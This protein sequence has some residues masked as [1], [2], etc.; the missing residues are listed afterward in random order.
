MLLRVVISNCI[1]L[2]LL[3]VLSG[4]NEG[5]YTD[6]IAYL[7]DYEELSSACKSTTVSGFHDGDGGQLNPYIL[8]KARHLDILRD[9]LIDNYNEYYNKYYRVTEDIDYKGNP[10]NIFYP[11]GDIYD[12]ELVDFVSPPNAKPFQGEFDGNNKTIKGLY[13]EGADLSY[14]GLFQHLGNLATV[15]NLTINFHYNLTG[16]NYF[17]GGLAAYSEATIDTVTAYG[18]ITGENLS[19]A[20]LISGYQKTGP[21]GSVTVG[22][23]IQSTL[24]EE[25]GAIAGSVSDSTIEDSTLMATF[26]LEGIIL[27]SKVNGAA[28]IGGV[29]GRAVTDV[30]IE[31]IDN[32]FKI[33][34]TADYCGGIVGSGSDSIVITNCDNNVNIVSSGD[35]VGGIGGQ[36][37]DASLTSVR[38]MGEGSR[39][40]EGNDFVAGLVGDA[41]TVGIYTSMSLVSVT[42][43]DSVCGGLVGRIAD[44]QIEDSSVFGDVTATGD[45]VGG[46]AGFA[47]NLLVDGDATVSGTSTIV[48]SDVEGDN[49]VGGIIG[50]SDSEL[51]LHNI[52]RRGDV[53]GTGDNVGGIAGIVTEGL[54]AKNIDGTA[55][56]SVDGTGG[57]NV[58]GGFGKISNGVGY[59]AY[60]KNIHISSS[61]VGAQYVGGIAGYL[62]ENTI[63]TQSSAEVDL[64][65]TLQFA[66]GIV[67]YLTSGSSSSI[68]Y[69]T[70][71]AAL[72]AGDISAAQ[73]FAGGICGKCVNG[74]TLDTVSAVI[75]VSSGNGKAG[76][77]AGSF[78]YGVINGS[79]ANTSVT[80]G[81]PGN[82]SVGGLIGELVGTSVS[83]SYSAG[84]VIGGGSVGGLVGNATSSVLA[85]VYSTANVE[86]NSLVVGSSLY[87]GG[88][89]GDSNAS[90]ISDCYS[91]G[92]VTETLVGGVEVDGGLIG[93]LGNASTLDRCFSTGAVLN[94][95][96]GAISNIDTSTATNIYWSTD[97]A[98]TSA[99]SSA[100]GTGYTDANLQTVFPYN[101][102]D[103]VNVW[104]IPSGNYPTL[105]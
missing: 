92:D 18:V 9:H 100:A 11:I 30:T 43:C 104:N 22:G 87:I 17:V 16:E 65:A 19:I 13:I 70:N 29:V 42:E 48:N 6:S 38:N 27:F 98:G 71:V 15:K 69:N 26:D 76:G 60:I 45:E 46:L 57:L 83:N 62:S 86:G 51:E 59:S 47:A 85:R 94:A 24:G 50:S 32:N 80:G 31:N 63:I 81:S 8:C 34:C 25:Y 7:E 96:G 74:I 66:G 93:R 82:T 95:S 55:T 102:F 41:S 79:N 39:S 73:S 3:A 103:F 58:S 14:V 90:N 89:I 53:S 37:I 4:C 78:K 88:L 40:I 64:E 5:M 20:G 21:I 44:S 77:L 68:I 35:Y 10:T 99:T 105:K 67:G 97:A 75:D 49:N 33:D 84:S 91:K 1:I 12:Y 52:E 23:Q 72:G 28:Y 101:G 54:I 61:V 56:F 2:L 36:L